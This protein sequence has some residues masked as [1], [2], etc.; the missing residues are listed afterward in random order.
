MMIPN[1]ISKGVERNNKFG[2]IQNEL[3][4]TVIDKKEEQMG[5]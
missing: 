1:L 5:K 2:R 4:V 3:D